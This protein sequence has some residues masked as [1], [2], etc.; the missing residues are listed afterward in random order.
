MPRL[1]AQLN[2]LPNTPVLDGLYEWVELAG[3]MY[4]VESGALDQITD[5]KMAQIA[6]ASCA[7]TYY[8]R[9]IVNTI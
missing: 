6:V 8:D 3:L 5:N 2:Y 1:L 7:Y 9:M 4:L